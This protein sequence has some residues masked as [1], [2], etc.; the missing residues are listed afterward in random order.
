MR[1]Y[2]FL[3]FYGMTYP[4]SR[5]LRPETWKIGTS[6]AWR[7]R[8]WLRVSW[9]ERGMISNPLWLFDEDPWAKQSL[10][11]SKER[12]RWIF[13]YKSARIFCTG[14]QADKKVLKYLVMLATL[15]AGIKLRKWL[16]QI[17][18]IGDI[19]IQDTELGR[20]LRHWAQLSNFQTFKKW[21]TPNSN[22]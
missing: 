5:T 11:A 1:N 6:I 13:L 4:H 22:S 18:D 15:R 20:W 10:Y 21:L 16:Q 14:F 9:D 19:E 12:D 17:R 7:V 8:V 3:T 2:F